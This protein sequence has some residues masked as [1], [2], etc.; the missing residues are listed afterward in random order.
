MKTLQSLTIS[1]LLLLVPASGKEEINRKWESAKVVSQDTHTN[2][3]TLDTEQVIYQW[4]QQGRNKMTL[5]AN[6]TIKYYRDKNS[7][8]VMDGKDNKHKFSLVSEKKKTN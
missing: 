8:F 3:V 4:K 6:E 7:F 5:P 1:L 2:V